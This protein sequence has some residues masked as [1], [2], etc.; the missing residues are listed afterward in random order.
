MKNI[1][2]ISRMFGAG[3][4]IIGREVANRLGYYYCDRDIILQSAMKSGH[5][6]PQYLREYDEKLPRSFGFGQSLFDFY[7]RPLSERIFEAQKKAILSIGE[8]RNCVIVGRNS[9]VIL[10]EFDHTLHV[11]VSA[12]DFFRVRNLK[13][14]MPESTEKEI[15]EKMK[16]VDKA[17]SKS[18]AY[19]T[20]TRFGDAKEYDLCLKSSTLGIDKCIDIIC[21]IAQDKDEAIRI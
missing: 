7:N 17:R 8:K 13:N 21:Q 12:T 16:S 1:I 14:H 9:N 11:F 3:G 19:Y 5:L 20:D 2:T 15:R 4:G 18:C 6:E 10:K